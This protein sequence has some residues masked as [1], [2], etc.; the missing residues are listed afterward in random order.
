MEITTQ[1]ELREYYG[2]PGDRARRKQLSA[3]DV[4][5]RNIIAASPFLVISSA[6]ADGKADVSPK[7]DAQGFVAVLDD[8]TLLIPDRPGN[9]R[10]DTMQNILDN[11]HVGL[12]FMVPG[13]NETL[14][15]NGRARVV[16][17]EE[18]LAPLQVKGKMPKAG[19]LVEVD[20]V[21]LHC[22]K[23]LIRSRLWDPETRIERSSLPTMSRMLSDQ[24]GGFDPEQFEKEYQERNKNGLY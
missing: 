4:H 14:R 3:L 6:A 5:C 1:R 20:E 8:K 18:L 16:L 11:P 13:L 15:V 9:A 17:D 12:L 23:A 2:E 19:L 10:V 7:G 21:F 22:A 24:I